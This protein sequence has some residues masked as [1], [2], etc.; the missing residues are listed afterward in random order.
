MNN[1]GESRFLS[2]NE[3]PDPRRTESASVVYE[4]MLKGRS[5][6]YLYDSRDDY[7][8]AWPGASAVL[9]VSW[10]YG[11]IEHQF[12]GLTSFRIKAKSNLLLPPYRS[13]P[14]FK[15]RY[16]HVIDCERA[17][18]TILFDGEESYREYDL[19]K[20]QDRQSYSGSVLVNDVANKVRFARY[21]Y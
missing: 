14:S 17:T 19:L 3:I 13:A 21:D 10:A 2:L 9:D 16:P 8:L 7:S 15:L 20:E 1:N 11:F 5:F 18:A 4:T 12:S 6:A